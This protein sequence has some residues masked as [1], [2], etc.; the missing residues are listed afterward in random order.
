[1]KV[2]NYIEGNNVEAAFYNL[3]ENPKCG[4]K[5][6]FDKN[7]MTKILHIITPFLNKNRLI[8]KNYMGDNHADKNSADFYCIENGVTKSMQMKSLMRKEG[9]ICPSLIGQPSS[10]SFDKFWNLSFN[11]DTSYHKERFN[12][13]KNNTQRFLNMQLKH[14]QTCDFIVLVDN[15]LTDPNVS[16][17]RKISNNWFTNRNIDFTKPEYSE[18]NEKKQKEKEFSSTLKVFHNNKYISVGELQFHYKSRN[19][20]KFRFDKKFL[21]EIGEFEHNDKNTEKIYNND[22]I[23][24]TETSSKISKLTKITPVKP[25]KC[26]SMLHKRTNHSKCPLNS[27]FNC[28]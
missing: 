3:I 23:D 6:E 17:I 14:L 2:E 25:C 9:K 21:I 20:V 24:I 13:I 18:Y 27:K 7:K 28:S 19:V 15:C 12:F 10:K 8:M 5:L 1:M 11:G 22:N 16:F 4:F 26:G